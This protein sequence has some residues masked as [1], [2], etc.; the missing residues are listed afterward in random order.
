MT[1][2]AIKEDEDVVTCRIDDEEVIIEK[3]FSNFLWGC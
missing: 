2:N 1:K 3:A